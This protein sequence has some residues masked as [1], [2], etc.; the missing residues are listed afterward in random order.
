MQ[1]LSFDEINWT[2]DLTSIPPSAKEEDGQQEMLIGQERALNAL[3][4]G[5]SSS[6]AA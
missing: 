1:P 4:F 2:C 5:M 3:Q 6:S